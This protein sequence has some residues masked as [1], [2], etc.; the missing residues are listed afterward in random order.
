MV[1]WVLRRVLAALAVSLVVGS[2]LAQAPEAMVSRLIVKFRDSEP[3]AD[4][5]MSARVARIAMDMGVALSHRRS[6]ALGAHVLALDHPLPRAEAAALVARLAHH[7]D[8]EFAQIDQRRRAQLV[9]ADTYVSAQIYLQN[10]AGGIS[11]IAAWDTTTGSPA[12]V[13]A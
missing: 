2:A 7:A 11:A 10:S 1:H 13:V 8:V 12:T 3:K 6:M 5:A 4:L 9:P